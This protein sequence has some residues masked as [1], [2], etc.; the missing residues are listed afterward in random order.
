MSI[1]LFYRKFDYKIILEKK[2]KH[3]LALLYTASLQELNAIKRYFDSQLAKKV[4]KANSALYLSLVF[5][6]KKSSKEIQFCVD[7]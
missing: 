1:L 7:Y 2:Q 3:G 5:L 6:I 4:I